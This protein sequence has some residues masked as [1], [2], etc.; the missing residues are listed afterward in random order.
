MADCINL[1]YRALVQV[2]AALKTGIR[3][4]IKSLCDSF[5]SEELLVPYLYTLSCNEST[6]EDTL[7]EKVLNALE[8]RVQIDKTAF[9][10]IT[11]VLKETVSL[12]YLAKK[13]ADKLEALQEE[14]ERIERKT[15][16]LAQQK[17]DE[18][19]MQ[20]QMANVRRSRPNSISPLRG[21]AAAHGPLTEPAALGNKSTQVMFPTYASSVGS[22]SG[23]L[24]SL[25]LESTQ[26]R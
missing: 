19:V 15:R 25:H 12:E 23:T 10:K 7:V 20:Q 4:G 6:S 17:Q 26:D 2:S 22:G 1:E 18:L 8:D 5:H 11:K 3:A 14:H 16:S 21:T 13:M 9:Y 24:T